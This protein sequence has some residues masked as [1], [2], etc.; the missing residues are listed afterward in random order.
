[1]GCGGSKE[2]SSARERSDAIEAQ[3][4]KDRMALR[5]EVKMCVLIY[6]YDPPSTQSVRLRRVRSPATRADSQRD[7][8]TRIP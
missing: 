2:D 7:E 8:I 4:K 6:C 5:N 1:M 3:L